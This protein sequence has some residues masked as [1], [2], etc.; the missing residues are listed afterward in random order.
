MVLF[1]ITLIME[2]LFMLRYWELH[3]DYQ[4][5]LLLNLKSLSLTEKSRVVSMDKSLSKL[6][7]LNLDNLLPV[8]KHL[9]SDTGRP[10]T[11]QQGII[12]SLV[13]MLESKKHSITNWA[14][15]VASD[16]LLCAACGFEFGKAPSHASYYDFIKRL[17]LSSH[18]E[19][20]KR[21]IKPKSFYSK[22]RMKL[23]AGQK[24]PTK[25]TGATA[26]FASLAERGKL[27][28][29]RPEKIFQEFL[30][31]C[32]VDKSADMGLLGNVNNF[33]IAMDGSCYNSGAS[34]HGVKICDCK[35]KGIYNCKCPRRYSD[36]DARWGW[37]S[38]HEQYFYGDTLFCTT[39]SDSP[40]DLPIYLRMQATRHDSILTIFALNEVRKL[41]PYIT[42]KNFIADG[43]M[44][45][46]ATYRLLHKWNMIP[47]I[48]L[49]SN[50]RIDY[51]KPHPGIL[52]FDD[53][54]NPICMGGIPYQHVGFSFPKGIKYRCWFDYHGIEKPC[55]CSD[56]KYGRTIYI[57]PDYDL[58]LFPPVPRNTKA[59]RDKFKTRT[60]VERSNKRI[61]VDYNVEA[62][63]CRSSKHRFARATFAAANIHLDAWIKHTGFST[64]N[65]LNN[66]DGS[67]A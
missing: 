46:Y 20:I 13:L 65:L 7:L 44:D 26:K 39:A 30:A 25:H 33:S 62:G 51:V 18:K 60:S 48:P 22:P 28:E 15:K 31:R 42:F 41:Y 52:C 32:V 11:N 59:F 21:K 14:K 36:P 23:K 17:W 10:A 4:R 6:Y 37:D 61:L 12:R 49:D 67:A 55:K 64:N 19:H 40:Y 2:V 16:R 53:D 43:A 47:F 45:N 27:R 35:S 57:K 58:R 54:G 9:Y 8:I 63:K 56:S 1:T 34:H 5:K 29:E 24:L 66:D 50:A 38:Y 3:E